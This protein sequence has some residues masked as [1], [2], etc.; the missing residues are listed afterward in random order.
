MALDS[1]TLQSTL[2]TLFSSMNDGLS[3][4]FANGIAGAVVTFVS[5]GTVNT[6][7]EGTVTGG[8]F[9]G[10]GNG[11]LTVTPTEL[12][13]TLITACNTMKNM[14]EG[15]D[16]FLAEQ[17]GKGLKQMADNGKVN[18]TVK[19]TLTAPN[20]ATSAMSGSAQGSIK[21]DSTSLVKALKSLFKDMYDN[22]E[23]K[24]EDKSYDGNMEFAKKLA[25]EIKTFFTSG[26]ITTKGLVSL[27]GSK[28]SGKLS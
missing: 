7:D 3:E 10:S 18:T 24:R 22:R 23:D 11:T 27:E 17:I 16:D 2:Y 12:A 9:E 6:D 26:N 25:S 19:G 15:G 8:T 21:C 28:G 5:T 20:E 1:E 4:T 13:S 14:T